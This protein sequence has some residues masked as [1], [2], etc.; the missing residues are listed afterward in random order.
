MK[1]N[2]STPKLHFGK[3]VEAEHARRVL[4]ANIPNGV[5]VEAVRRP[6]F[7]THHTAIIRG[8]DIIEAACEDGSWMAW[9]WVAYVSKTEVVTHTLWHTK[10]ETEDAVKSS[11]HYIK[12]RGPAA[13][14]SIME[15]DTKKVV[16]DRFD[17]EAAANKRLASHLQSLAR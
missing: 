1:S 5:P 4:R 10:V 13:K 8:G 12:W 15:T 6:S 9:L 14:W 11:T 17:T 3:L 16:E 7:F 2:G